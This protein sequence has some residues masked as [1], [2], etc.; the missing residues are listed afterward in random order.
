MSTLPVVLTIAGSDSSAGAGVQADLKTLGAIGAY[1]VCA[2]TCIV[3]EA[4]GKV[5]AIQPADPALVAAQIQTLFTAFP[6]A[7][8]KTGMLFSRAIIE[9][10]CDTLSECFRGRRDRPPLIVD[11]VMIATSGDPLLNQDAKTLLCERLLPLANLVTPNLDEAGALLGRKITRLAEMDVAGDELVAR[12]GA[13]F[14]LKG[15]HLQGENKAT[16]LLCTADGARHRF[17]A[18]FVT[19]V[20]THGTGCTT[21][22]AIAGYLA[23]GL[24]LPESVERAK[25]YV[26][27]TIRK[28]LRW[29]NERTITDALNHF[30]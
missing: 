22:A 7:T 10:V 17:T 29:Q 28:H 14:L 30:A 18:P 1:G 23:R 5:T 16:D 26:T 25:L 4:P 19:G 9:T 15:G 8:I 6:I 20:A 11:P 13:S 12:F 3:A 24:S 21:S 27:K 2:V